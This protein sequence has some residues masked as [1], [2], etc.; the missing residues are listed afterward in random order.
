MKSEG[1][2][3]GDLAFILSRNA[4]HVNYEDLPQ[5]VISA[6]KNAVLDTL[7]VMI[8]A[9][10]AVQACKHVA[11]FVKDMGGREESTIINL[12]GKVPAPMAAFANGAL[13]HALDYD[14]IK[15]ETG[16]RIHPSSTVIPAAFSIAEHKQRINGR[17]FLTAIALGRDLIIR[18]ARAV[19]GQANWFTWQLT[20]VL[21]TFAAAMTSCKLLGLDENQMVDAL[22]IALSQAAGTMELRFASG[23]DLG[24]MY[25]SFPSKG[26]VLSS[27]M[28]QRGIRGLGTCLEGK[29][30]LF[31]S[32]FGGKYG[33]DILTAELGKR[34]DG[35]DV[36]FKPWPACALSHVYI[37]AALQILSEHRIVPEQVEVVTAFVGKRCQTLC[38]PLEARR[39]PATVLD[40]KYNIIFPIAIALAKGNVLIDDFSAEAVKDEKVLAIAE[41]VTYQYEPKFEDTGGV[42]P[43]MVEIKLK[44]G[45]TYGKRVDAPFGHPSKPL[46]HERLIAK[47]K[48]CVAHAARPPTSEIIEKVIESIT[49]M[50][51]MKDVAEIVELVT[52]R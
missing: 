37:D 1:E 47:F 6:T 13:A 30:G 28:A 49:R 40:A 41:K 15:W 21:G 5:E 7:G 33:R 16:A 51:E 8:A 14:D 22:G 2:V 19:G 4:V 18:M 27:L 48:D 26:G 35:V 43:G 42:P 9:T 32:Y 31:N 52:P 25:A 44:M 24:G 39:K 36:S 46:S 3:R 17:K 29:A 20:T 23:S 45:Q 34:F 12:G 11:D 10:G 50:E 38:E